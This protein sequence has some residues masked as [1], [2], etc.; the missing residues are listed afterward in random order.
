MLICQSGACVETAAARTVLVPYLSQLSEPLLR[1][2]LSEKRAAVVGGKDVPP[3]ILLKV[4][5]NDPSALRYISTMLMT[6]P[7][8][9]LWDIVHFTAL[10]DK[11]T[12]RLCRSMQ[13]IHTDV[14]LKLRPS[15]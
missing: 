5:D 1:E 9:T 15:P 13:E 6:M 10:D 2:E 4:M 8:V 14:K 11:A 3:I 12:K 7:L